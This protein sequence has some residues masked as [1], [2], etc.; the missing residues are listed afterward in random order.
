MGNTPAIGWCEDVPPPENVFIPILSPKPGKP[1]RGFLLS[2][3]HVGVWTHY[4]NERT[5]PH[6]EPHSSCLPCQYA[7]AKRWKAYFGCW[8]VQLCRLVMIELTRRSM[9]ESLNFPNA[10]RFFR[11][12]LELFVSRRGSKA[13]SPVI[14][15]LN[16]N[17]DPGCE[18]PKPFNVQKALERIW[19][20][21]R[22]GRQAS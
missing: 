18:L 5:V 10:T 19:Y 20:G 14:F 8:S 16:A 7:L 11:R 6:R 2:D 17:K 4:Y 15:E 21:N 22:D 13:N 3:A 1:V 12:G 9:E